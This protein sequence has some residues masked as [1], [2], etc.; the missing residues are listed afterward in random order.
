MNLRKLF[1]LL[2]LSSGLGLFSCEDKADKKL[3]ILGRKE[4]VDKEVGGEIMQDTLYHTIAP[5][6]FVNQDGTEI[7]NDTY[8]GKIYVSDFFFTT[9]PTICPIMKSQML[10]V[11]EAYQS[12]PNVFILSHTIDPEHDT[13]ALLN[14]YAK[15]LG[16]QAPKWNFVTG[17]K[18]KIYEIGQQSYMVTAYEDEQA[19]GGY[20]HSGAFLLIDP[21]GR[22]RGKYDGTKPE[23][24]EALIKDIPSLK[25]EYGMTSDDKSSL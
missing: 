1:T 15:R 19:D 8:R 22:V 13:V 21:E 9:C 20:I 18:E 4:I 16:V 23:E 5:F 14:D 11:Y 12:D 2:A 24:V 10:R 25:K 17:D 3:P 6:K 7:T